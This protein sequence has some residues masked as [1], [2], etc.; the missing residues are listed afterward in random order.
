MGSRALIVHPSPT[1]LAEIREVL[2]AQVIADV[3]HTEADAIR[4]LGEAEYAVVIVDQK[5]PPNL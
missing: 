3:A 4:R 5:P 2:K 1:A